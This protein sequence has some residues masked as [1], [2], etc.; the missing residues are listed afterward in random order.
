MCLLPV[1]LTTDLTWLRVV[2][3]MREKGVRHRAASLLVAGGN[4]VEKYKTLILIFCA[5]PPHSQ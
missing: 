1:R 4:K 3:E 2:V 5:A